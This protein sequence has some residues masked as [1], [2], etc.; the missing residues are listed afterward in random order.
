MD[1]YLTAKEIGVELGV[2]EQTANQKIREYCEAKRINRTY[3]GSIKPGK[4]GGRW[5]SPRDVENLIKWIRNPQPQERQND[6]VPEG[7]IKAT[8]LVPVE[9]VDTELP[10]GF[11]P[12]AMVRFF[13]GVAGQGTNTSQMVK[14]VKCIFTA[15]ETVMDKKLE[16]Q[17][18]AL[19]QAESDHRE[20]I[21]MA[22]E[23]KEDLKLKALESRLLAERHTAVTNQT[24][25]AFD[26]LMQMGKVE[27]P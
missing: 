5:Y 4:G 14:V 18:I 21:A 6:E 11:D 3:F 16:A 7:F 19:T 23:A 2:T 13:D 9:L 24:Q 25:K 12:A 17:R 8:P 10:E 22:Q 1:K 26:K 20:I 27:A 15:A